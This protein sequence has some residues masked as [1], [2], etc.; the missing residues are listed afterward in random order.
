MLVQLI[1]TDGN[2]ETGLLG[3]ETSHTCWW[4]AGPVRPIA[5]CLLPVTSRDISKTASLLLRLRGSRNL[6]IK[7]D[8]RTAKLPAQMIA[9]VQG[10]FQF[11][12]GLNT[13]RF[14]TNTG[15]LIAQ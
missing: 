2:L 13:E 6:P 15:R 5:A 1:A 9:S 7:R 3:V 12:A 14:S 8:S 11:K 4:D 10:H